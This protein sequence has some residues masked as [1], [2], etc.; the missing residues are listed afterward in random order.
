MKKPGRLRDDFM[1]SIRPFAMPRGS[2]SAALGFAFIWLVFFFPSILI[3]ASTSLPLAGG[4]CAYKHY[5]GEAEIISI[6][7]KPDAPETYEIKFSFHPQ[8]MIR[9]AF[10]KV[11]GRQWPL[12]LRDHSPPR[13]DFILRYAIKSGRRFP[14]VMKVIVKGACT[15]VLFDFPTIGE[16]N[17]TR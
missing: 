3:A 5:K 9:E 8:E 12:L 11:E 17:E 13:E 10:V 14:C 1:K 16:T 2:G 7:P 15:P 6:Q 4:P